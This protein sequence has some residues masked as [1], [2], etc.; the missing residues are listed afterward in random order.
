MPMSG[1]NFEDYPEVQ[2]I[3]HPGTFELRTFIGARVT[4]IEA[5]AVGALVWPEFVEY[6]DGVF[7]AALFDT[8]GLDAW[9]ARAGSTVAS[10]EAMANHLHLWDAF[11]A[12]SD[13]DR[14]ALTALGQLMNQT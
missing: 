12:Q 2:A 8:A 13:E 7:L 11:P 14:G 5:V 9:F 4:P 10:V 6:R 1:V 3:F